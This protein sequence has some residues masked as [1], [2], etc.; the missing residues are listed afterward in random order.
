[1]TEPQRQEIKNFVNAGG[2][3]VVDAAGGSS[4]FA[5]S[6]EKELTALFG[7]DTVT[8]AMATPLPL[9]NGLYTLP[10]AKI[11]SI[12]YRT[13]ARRRL[14]ALKTPQIC[15]IVQ[16]GR[17]VAYYSRHDLS[18]GLVGQ[19]VDGIDGYDPASA[20]AIMRNIV[21]QAAGSQ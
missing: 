4:P 7:A 20:T 19:Q 5:A 16:N 8:Q 13:F 14:G 1:L 10:S 12:E 6:A 17:I 11:E 3:L 2:T 15:G 18:A 21:L 9:E